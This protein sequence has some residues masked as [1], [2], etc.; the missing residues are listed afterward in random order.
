MEDDVPNRGDDELERSLLEVQ[1][2]IETTMALHRS[3]SR[4]EALITVLDQ[5]Y[6]AVL[7]QAQQL[8]AG[9]TRS[10]DIVHARRRGS[11]EQALRTERELI[12]GAGE[13]VV[14]RLLSSPE[15]IDEDY[16]R[17]QLGRQRPVGIRIARIPPLQA[18]I[19]DGAVAVVVAHSAV[20]RRASVIRVP[21]VLHTLT[22]LFDNVWAHAVPA[23]ERI[24]F[25]D[26]DRAALAR[27]I[28]GA[29]HA[30]VTDEVAARELNI[31][32]RTYRRHVAD[33]MALLGA[34][35]RFQAGVRAAELGL[36]PPA[37]RP[38]PPRNGTLASS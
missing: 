18:M 15:L 38:G 36:L 32:V 9:A 19:A 1:S 12:Y 11:D 16:V 3:R 8:I 26:R 7:D 25:G 28:L 27:R 20:G 6:D 35:S 5:D 37:T 22:T 10:I 14:V 2:L 23:G 4:E 21:E 33:I 24:V 17:E 31:S 29:L 30:S 13:G 34:T